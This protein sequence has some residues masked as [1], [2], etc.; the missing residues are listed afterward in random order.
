MDLSYP[1]PFS[2]NSHIQNNVYLG[3]PFLHTLPTVDDI[4]ASILVKGRGCHLT[5][6]D[7]SRAFRYITID[8]KDYAPLGIKHEGYF[9][10]LACPFGFRLGSSFF[11]L[12]SD[13]VCHV[14]HQ[15]DYDVINYIDDTIIYL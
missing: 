15:I 5:K 1:A 3:T 12:I 8:P 14:M 9:H 11:Q 2:V 10:D 7:I 13:E 4:M 6:I